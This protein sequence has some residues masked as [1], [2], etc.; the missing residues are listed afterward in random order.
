[1]SKKKIFGAEI[2]FGFDTNARFLMKRSSAGTQ[3]GN[4]KAKREASARSWLMALMQDGA[5]SPSIEIDAEEN[6]NLWQ[7][8]LNAII[9]FHDVSYHVQGVGYLE[10]KSIIQQLQTLNYTTTDHVCYVIGATMYKATLVA[11]DALH[12]YHFIQQENMQTGMQRVIRIESDAAQLYY[13][14]LQW[15]KIYRSDKDTPSIRMEIAFPDRFPVEPPFVRI[16]SPRF[17]M[18]TGH[19]TIGGS[20]CTELLTVSDS[21]KGWNSQILPEVFLP[22]ITSLFEN[23]KGRLDFR[24]YSI[25]D[26]TKNEAH[27]AFARVADYHRRTGWN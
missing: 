20:I 4:S 6:V 7:V 27:A 25:H 9:F 3:R 19:V 21:G 18:H 2:F 17:Q 11:C 23:G 5:K 8:T 13:D 1:M 12:A 10:D 16:V 24:S 22:T 15:F 26:Y 14:L